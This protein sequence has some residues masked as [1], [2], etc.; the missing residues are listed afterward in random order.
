MANLTI[1][2]NDDFDIERDVTDIPDG[3]TIETAWL[4]LAAQ[5]DGDDLILKEITTDAEIGVGEI[6]IDS[7]GETRVVFQLTNE[8]T[9]DLTR[10]IWYWYGITVETDQGIVRQIETGRLV[11]RSS[12]VGAADSAG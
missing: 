2:I 3:Q 12:I 5:E 1:S 11:A 10:D 7:A 8:D 6:Q 9:A 4:A